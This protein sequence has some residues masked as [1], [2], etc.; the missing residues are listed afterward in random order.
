MKKHLFVSLLLS[1]SLGAIANEP[2]DSAVHLEIVEKCYNTQRAKLDTLFEASQKF[3]P[4]QDLSVLGS[5]DITLAD[6]VL[7]LSTRLNRRYAQVVAEDGTADFPQV[8]IDF[9]EYCNKLLTGPH[10]QE[11]IASVVS[12]RL[13]LK[14]DK[15]KNSS[16]KVTSLKQHSPKSQAGGCPLLEKVATDE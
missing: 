11:R 2:S 5:D 6:E 3:P 9:E 14:P 15:Y 4:A 13:S 1:L 7:L 8:V 12:Q 10:L 16:P